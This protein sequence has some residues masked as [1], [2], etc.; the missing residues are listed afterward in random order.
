MVDDLPMPRSSCVMVRVSRNAFT[1]VVVGA[2]SSIK[3]PRVGLECHSSDELLHIH[4][5]ACAC[6]ELLPFC[7]MIIE[8]SVP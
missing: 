8:L 7:D 2:A 6:D 1:I 3:T 5:R 4:V